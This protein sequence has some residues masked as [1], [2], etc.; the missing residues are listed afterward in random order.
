MAHLVNLKLSA[1]ILEPQYS[2]RVRRANDEEI[3]GHN[4]LAPESYPG[5]MV[6]ADRLLFDGTFHGEHA[7]LDRQGSSLDPIFEVKFRE[8]IFEMV[9]HGV[10][11]NL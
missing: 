6:R 5:T 3:R 7:F 10:L 11:G 2:R 9:I 8:D 1:N 4:F